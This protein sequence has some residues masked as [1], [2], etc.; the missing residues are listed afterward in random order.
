MY[1]TARCE[2]VFQ[3]LSKDLDLPASEEINVVFDW[4]LQVLIGVR[5]GAGL[6]PCLSM[7]FPDERTLQLVDQSYYL[8]L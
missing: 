4:R 2:P 3:L 8:R 5:E 7:G 1:C 6:T